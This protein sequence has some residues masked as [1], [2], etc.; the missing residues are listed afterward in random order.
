[1]SSPIT[2]RSVRRKSGAIDAQP[3][4][5]FFRLSSS[6]AGCR[7]SREPGCL[8]FSVFFLPSSIFPG[9]AQC[10][11]LT[12]FRYHLFCAEPVASGVVVKTILGGMFAANSLAIRLLGQE[13]GPGPSRGSEQPTGKELRS[14]DRSGRRFRASRMRHPLAEHRA[15]RYSASGPEGGR[16]PRLHCRGPIEANARSPR[17]AAHE[18]SSTTP[19]SWPH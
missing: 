8:L 10:P 7:R 15:N 4:V 13:T 9:A 16:L 5:F 17:E 1:M 2:S 11:S 6:A 3:P 19:L 14:D 12:F 18:E